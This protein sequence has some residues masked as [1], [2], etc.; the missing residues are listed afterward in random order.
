V[1]VMPERRPQRDGGVMD[2]E[3]N[4]MGVLGESCGCARRHMREGWRRS[5]R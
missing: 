1:A 4:A 5:W 2:A 3:M